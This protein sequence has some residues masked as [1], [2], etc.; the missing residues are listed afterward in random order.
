L[1]HI[2]EP[3][4]CEKC[5][6]VVKNPTF[7]RMHKHQ[8]GAVTGEICCTSMSKITISR[9]MKTKHKSAEEIKCSY[10]EFTATRNDNCNQHI[11]QIH[12]ENKLTNTYSCHACDFTS[13]R[14]RVLKRVQEA[15]GELQEKNTPQLSVEEALA[16]SEELNTSDI[17]IKKNTIFMIKKG[18]KVPKY[19]GDKLKICK[20]PYS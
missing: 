20:R 4:P 13:L 10:C 3:V 16:W 14:N 18:I 15:N 1:F 5:G 8:C 19:I 7:L 6:K 17:S 12:K 2:E 9:H 11:Q